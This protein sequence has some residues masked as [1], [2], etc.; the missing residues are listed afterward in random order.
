MKQPITG[1][2]RNVTAPE[3]LVKSTIITRAR[4]PVGTFIALTLIAALLI[5]A[6][7]YLITDGGILTRLRE[8][9]GA[10]QAYFTTIQDSLKKYPRPHLITVY[11]FAIVAGAAAVG[12]LGSFIRTNQFRFTTG[13]VA[14]A[15]EGGEN[16]MIEKRGLWMYLPLC[17][18]TWFPLTALFMLLDKWLA[19]ALLRRLLGND[20]FNRFGGYL[21]PVL[22]I[23]L[24][25]SLAFLLL[26][27]LWKRLRP[28]L[29]RS[30]FLPGFR[31]R[32]P[33]S[34]V[35][36]LEIQNSGE[37]RTVLVLILANGSA[38]TVQG[39][40]VKRLQRIGAIL[41]RRLGLERRDF[42]TWA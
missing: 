2:Q 17:L 40:R 22:W 10:N 3:V 25:G 14:G 38:W 41:S 37:G 7:V 36:R 8:K 28:W 1:R 5:F 16:G 24:S 39:G 32:L 30:L 19:T 35:N 42:A 27:T 26:W 13:R 15:V 20:L 34:K 11:A 29:G 23:A 6:G 18:L 4:S 31:R 33:F 9:T 12:V 21:V